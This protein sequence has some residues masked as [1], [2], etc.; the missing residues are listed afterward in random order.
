MQIKGLVNEMINILKENGIASDLYAQEFKE[1]LTY[2]DLNELKIILN[3]RNL[4]RLVDWCNNSRPLIA[5]DLLFRHTFI[6]HLVYLLSSVDAE[7]ANEFL[8]KYIKRNNIK[9]IILQFYFIFYTI[10]YI[11]N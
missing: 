6:P 8:M 9:N 11:H 2:L 10:N 3:T 7:F 1:T 4:H 5:D